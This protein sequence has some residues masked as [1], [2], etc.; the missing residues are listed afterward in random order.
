MHTQAKKKHTQDYK[1]Y[2]I[3]F[4]PVKKQHAKNKTHFTSK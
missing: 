2:E 1:N 4:D 3:F